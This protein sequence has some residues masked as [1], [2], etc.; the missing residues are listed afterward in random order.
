M[1]KW[2]IVLLVIFTVSCTDN[3]VDQEWLDALHSIKFI[4]S[5]G[6][7]VQVNSNGDVEVPKSGGGTYVFKFDEAKS[8]RE[9][10]YKENNKSGYTGLKIQD[11]AL[12][13]VGTK[14]DVTS[15][16]TL[17][18]KKDFIDFSKLIKELGRKK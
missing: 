17:S 14:S 9:A 12:W 11:T 7:S 6:V 10:F 1:K 5:N 16:A 13:Q 2:Y 8:E 15:G 4:D 18:Q 3:K